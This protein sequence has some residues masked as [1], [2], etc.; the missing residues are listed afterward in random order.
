MADMRFIGRRLQQLMIKLNPLRQSATPLQP[1]LP[2]FPF[3][4]ERVLSHVNM[5]L[6]T[7]F[8][9]AILALLV[10]PG[11]CLVFCVVCVCCRLRALE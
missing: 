2:L 6:R 4:R 8:S 9:K 1:Q 10:L 11:L 7:G 5:L 3:A